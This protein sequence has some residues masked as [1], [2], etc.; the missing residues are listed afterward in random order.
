MLSVVAKQIRML[1]GAGGEPFTAFV[2]A[3]LWTHARVHGL[4]DADVDTT[5]RVNIPDGGVDTTVRRAVGNDPV[6]WMLDS[7]TAWQYKATDNKNVAIS[8]MLAGA[9]ATAR[10]LAGDAFRLALADS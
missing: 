8:G 10:I 1:Q 5:I 6:G 3:L 7:A 2:D 9:A 4:A